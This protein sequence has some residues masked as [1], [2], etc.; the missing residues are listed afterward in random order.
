MRSCPPGLRCSRGGR[1]DDD[2]RKGGAIG[3]DPRTTEGTMPRQVILFSGG[4]ADLPLE[5]LAARA[6]EWGYQ[7]LDLCCRG[8]HF[9]IQRAS[10]E[11]EYAP[12]KLDLL[13][14]LELDVPVL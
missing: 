13:R 4:W 12:A 8:D 10:T 11:D 5:D 1:D 9:E 14:K 7:G 2:G 6:A 3:R